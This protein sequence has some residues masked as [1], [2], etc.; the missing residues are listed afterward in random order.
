MSLPKSGL[1][2]YLMDSEGMERKETLSI[3]LS[4]GAKCRPSGF[5]SWTRELSFVCF[6]NRRDKDGVGLGGE[7]AK[8]YRT[9]VGIMGGI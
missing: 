3:W 2:K 7:F 6:F 4:L 9:L 5:R 1:L 8:P